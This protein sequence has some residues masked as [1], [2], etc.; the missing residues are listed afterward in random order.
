MIQAIIKDAYDNSGP[1]KSMHMINKAL[2]IDIKKTKYIIS[3]LENSYKTPYAL[4]TSTAVFEF[5]SQSVKLE[6]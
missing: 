6:S 5:Q 1:K 2:K 3:S 4:D